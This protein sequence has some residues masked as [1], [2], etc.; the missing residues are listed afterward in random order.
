M[1]IDIGFC[2]K[3]IKGKD[4]NVDYKLQK[5]IHICH[6]HFIHFLGIFNRYHKYV[7]LFLEPI[8]SQS[9]LF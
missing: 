6:V 3:W 5:R 9:K 2:N 4:K 8:D 1:V 7:D